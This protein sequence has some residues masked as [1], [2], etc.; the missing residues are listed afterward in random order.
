MRK[1]SYAEEKIEHFVAQMKEPMKRQIRDAMLLGVP[2]EYLE[3]LLNTNLNYSCRAYLIGCMLDEESLEVIK[4]LAEKESVEGMCLERRQLQE[5]YFLQKSSVYTEY[6]KLSKAYREQ[7][8]LAK[9]QIEK[10]QATIREMASEKDKMER[11][12][13]EQA[14][15]KD[16]RERFEQ[17]EQENKKL[18]DMTIRLEDER[19]ELAEKVQE[20]QK[21]AD[22]VL[23][24]M[25]EVQKEKEE[26]QR[27]LRFIS[28]G[29]KEAVN[30]TGLVVWEEEE[31][32]PFFFRQ[33]KKLIRKVRKRKKDKESQKKKE[34]IEAYLK[35][36]IEEPDKI[37]FM[38]GLY[39]DG[40][41]VDDMQKISKCGHINEMNQMKESLERVKCYQTMLHGEFKR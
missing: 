16:E 14:G 22:A 27:R 21:S 35:A 29:K 10:Y 39:Q 40:W 13:H 8:D 25:K 4:K 7:M 6:Q 30:E 9:E 23:Q 37:E 11:T 1:V 32:P 26:L 17:L 33:M 15:Q 20:S 31:Q 36:E 5:K 38:I 19:S 28:E 2:K 12:G 3:V 41:E 18:R 34:F 24:Q